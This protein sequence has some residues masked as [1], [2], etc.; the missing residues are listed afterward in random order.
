MGSASP[1]FDTHRD[2]QELDVLASDEHTVIPG[3]S[4]H[5][6]GTRHDVDA[7]AAIN[8]EVGGLVL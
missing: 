6:K 2:R 8:A 1:E 7:G 4:E 3:L 5:A